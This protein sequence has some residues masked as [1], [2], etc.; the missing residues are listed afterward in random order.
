MINWVTH[1]KKKRLKGVAIPS[2]KAFEYLIYFDD[3]RCLVNG[4]LLGC[5]EDVVHCK[6][7]CEEHYMSNV[8][9]EK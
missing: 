3:L 8:G 9:Y 6:S 1:K 7:L 4:K 5:A 2:P